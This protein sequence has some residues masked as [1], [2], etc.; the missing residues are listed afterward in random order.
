MNDPAKNSR[1]NNKPYEIQN[2]KELT[3]NNSKKYI[4]YD[5]SAIE[6]PKNFPLSKENN[7][8]LYTDPKLFEMIRKDL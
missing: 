3:F 5:P 1:L 7:A 6:T 8:S 4:S 2:H